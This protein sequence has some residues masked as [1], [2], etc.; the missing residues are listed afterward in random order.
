GR[1]LDDAAHVRLR[2]R[3]GLP[4]RDAAAGQG[5][6]RVGPAPRGV[7]TDRGPGDGVKTLRISPV[8]ALFEATRAVR[9]DSDLSTALQ[10][11]AR[12]ISEA[13][14]FHTVAVNLYRPAWD[15][16]CVETVHGN[17]HAR[18][19]L[20]GDARGWSTWEPL[21][22]GR[23][24]RRGAYFI[25]SGEFDLAAYECGRYILCLTPG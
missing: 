24:M 6:G 2:E 13:L 10:T 17:E 20:L 21:L 22:D 12:V 25:P 23:F 19:A 9:T 16:F 7:D 18:E 8:R 1:S 14:G 15:D 11:I 4:L 5:D 3:A